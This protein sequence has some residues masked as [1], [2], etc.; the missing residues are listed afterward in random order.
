MDAAT[1]SNAASVRWIHAIVKGLCTHTWC[2]SCKVKAEEKATNIVQLLD[3]AVFKYLQAELDLTEADKRKNIMPKECAHEYLGKLRIMLPVLVYKAY[4]AFNVSVA[5]AGEVAESVVS[6]VRAILNPSA[7]WPMQV[8]EN[9]H[10]NDKPAVPSGW[11]VAG[12]VD[13]AVF[14]YLRE[15]IPGLTEQQKQTLALTAEDERQVKELHRDSKLDGVHHML[16]RRIPTVY[17]SA[18]K[19]VLVASSVAYKTVKYV[20][21]ALDFVA[22]KYETQLVDGAVLKFLRRELPDAGKPA[23]RIS[24]EEATDLLGGYGLAGL[25]VLLQTRI[26]GECGISSLIARTVANESAAEVESRFENLLC[27]GIRRRS[28]ATRRESLM[29]SFAEAGY[30]GDGC[31]RLIAYLQRC[32]AVYPQSEEGMAIPCTAVVQ[33]SGFGKS[34]L[35][36][37]L[38]LETVAR[39]GLGMRVF[40]VSAACLGKT[41]GFPETTS[42]LSRLLF[43]PCQTQE[44]FSRVLIAIYRYAQQNWRAAGRQWAEHF[45]NPSAEG[46]TVTKLKATRIHLEPLTRAAKD[47]VVDVQQAEN[48][49][50]RVVILAVDDAAALLSLDEGNTSCWRMLLGALIDA[51]KQ[52]RAAY[53]GGGIFAVVADTDPRIAGLVLPSNPDASTTDEQA[54]M[55]PPF[56]L[57]ET[58]DVFWERSCSELAM[59]ETSAYQLAVAQSDKEEGLKA[60]VTMGRP[61]WAS[62]F[63]ATTKQDCEADTF[64]SG[65]FTAVVALASSKLLVGRDPKDPAAYDSRNMFGVASLLCRLGLRPRFTSPLA[66][67]AVAGLMAVLAYVSPDNDGLLC[68]YNSDP[69]LALGA[70]YLWHAWELDGKTPLSEFVLPQLKKLLLQEELSDDNFPDLAA[71]IVLLLTVDA[72][73]VVETEGSSHGLSSYVGR[74][75]SVRTFL[76]VLGGTRPPLQSSSLHADH[77]RNAFK[78]WQCRWQGWKMGFCQ[79]VPLPLEPTEETLW[80]LLGRRAAGVLRVDDDEVSLVIPMFRRTEVSFLL[81]QVKTRMEESD[82]EEMH[83]LSFLSDGNPLRAKSLVEVVFVSM[84]PG[85]KV[86]EGE[87][88]R[89]VRAGRSAE[90]SDS[91]FFTF[92]IRSVTPW[93][94]QMEEEMYRVVLETEAAQLMNLVSTPSVATELARCALFS[95]SEARAASVGE[96]IQVVGSA[97]TGDPEESSSSSDKLEGEN[98][99]SDASMSDE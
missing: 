23:L 82:E 80:F 25:R 6:D 84:S 29:V 39:A 41:T 73:V 61:L 34:R 85:E 31:S 68:T 81:T 89:Y 83:P 65:A 13:D 75:V 78:A 1:D 57:A 46:Y 18:T 7:Q 97:S 88:D 36:Y 62:W 4:E 74:F 24:N 44:Y 32:W 59:D 35:L 27:N 12:I 86:A 45:T 69:V 9:L 33:S 16:A 30:V 17:K 10:S 8:V 55:F 47:W 87:P 63:H 19:S 99:E 51:N 98:V 54:V 2:L 53:P 67:R 5:T 48:D 92:C 49:P 72:S 77:L 93:E 42:Q 96:C 11:S 28:D 91:P 37:Q 26:Q 94:V 58:M 38:A 60:L 43:D 76:T 64:D 95:H 15:E 40:Y 14:K 56:V 50:G 21:A 22:N 20:E 70:A 3:D 90:D 66:S 79:F 71:R 52:I